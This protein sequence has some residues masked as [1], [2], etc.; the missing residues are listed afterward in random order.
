[1]LE[2]VH[3][4]S[5]IARRR[6]A[7]NTAEVVTSRY[8]QS[9]SVTRSIG[10]R[11]GPRSVAAVPEVT[12]ITIPRDQ[13]A[14]F[15]LCSDGVWSV[16]TPEELRRLAFTSVSAEETS[17]IISEQARSRRISRRL[18][19]DDVSVIVVDVNPDHFPAS[20]IRCCCIS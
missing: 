13:F 7:P 8:N 11:W 3:D 5:F 18:I 20:E 14:R 19:N 16:L 1:M 9:L 4:E 15:V 17:L 2:V 10:D 12:A 6:G